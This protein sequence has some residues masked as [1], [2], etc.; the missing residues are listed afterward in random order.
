ME[1][2]KKYKSQIYFHL[3]LNVVFSIFITFS[4][5]YN[6]PLRESKDHF[7]YFI[8]LILLQF[9]LFGYLYLLSLNKLLFRIFFPL[10]FIILSII[11]FWVYTLDISIS[12]AIIQ[13]ALET[14]LDVVIELM[15]YPFLI[16]VI[17][18]L[19]TTYLILKYHNNV[20]KNRLKSP[21]TVVALISLITFTVV[22]RKRHD[23][24]STRLPYNFIFGL[25]QYYN[26]KDISFKKVKKEIK[27][28]VDSLN[29]VFIL[30]ESV[31]A[32]HL[33]LNGYNR[34]TNPLL[35]KRK[36]II[37]YSNAYTPLTYTA[38]SIPQILTD[39]SIFDN[40]EKARY[41]LID[42]LNNVNIQ[43]NWIG[44]QT[45]EESYEVFIKQS[46]FNTILNPMNSELSFQKEYDEGLIPVFEKIYK[47]FKNQF[48]V[49]HMMGSHWWYETR[50]PKSFQHFKPVIKSKYIPSNS[51]LEMI[52]S[53]DN[54]LLY[55]DYFLNLVI[56][57]VEKNDSKSLIIYLSDHGELLGENNMWLH[58]QRG[59]KSEN[60][61]MI[62]WY[63]DSFEKHYPDYIENI[64][65]KRN[66]KI[67]LDF[68]FPTILDL[69]KI[70]GISYDKKK[71]L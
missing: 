26:Q 35:S 14:K 55:L 70:E 8:H 25:H 12:M 46:K 39:A 23:T 67:N 7:F 45:P 40:N 28:N 2:I 49:L 16:Y 53:Y 66:T 48:S 71:K 62:I 43:T 54:T 9:S 59:Q 51:K 63:S 1:V 32:D 38:I 47:P 33:Q 36:N 65:R 15:S 37:S 31:R 57:K 19:I 6:L 4:S 29:I 50:Y 24:F 41:S 27:S 58:A 64:K 3:V 20:K 69:Y 5:Y 18:V 34:N 22:D 17:T 68:F 52:N 56:S 61:A 44:N 11:G 10:F 21:L 42:V 60:P 13:A 30:G